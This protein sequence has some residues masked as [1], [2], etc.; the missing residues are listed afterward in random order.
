MLNAKEIEKL[1]KKLLKL[2][3]INNKIYILLNSREWKD[4]WEVK[5]YLELSHKIN[6]DNINVIE[7]IN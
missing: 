6:L 4:V 7:L 2:A 1:S 3:V 5:G